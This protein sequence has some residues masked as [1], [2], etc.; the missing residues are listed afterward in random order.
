MKMKARLKDD[1][2]HP[3]ALQMAALFQCLPEDLFSEEQQRSKLEHNRAEA[4]VTYA[5]VALLTQSAS[6]P[7]LELQTE[8]QDARKALSQ[9]L[10]MLTP[11][12]ERIIRLRFGINTKEM[13]H[14]EIGEQIG[15]SGERVRSIV[16]KALRM[17]KHPHSSRRLREGFY[18]IEDTEI[19]FNRFAHSFIDDEIFAAM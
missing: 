12:E 18:K 2:W 1:S 17:L 15:I 5:E 3:L 19:S 11:R 9:V 10:L 16:K 6:R 4:E 13:T 8:A 14:N 7:R